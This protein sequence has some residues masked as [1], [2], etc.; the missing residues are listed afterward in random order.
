MGRI[1]RLTERDLTRLV[2]RVINESM[3]TTLMKP[4]K[5]SN[6]KTYQVQLIGDM[7]AFVEPNKA[8]DP[9]THRETVI[10]LNKI[11]GFTY[12]AIPGATGYVNVGYVKKNCYKYK[13]LCNKL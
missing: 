11:A 8:N 6:G 7:I 2:K 10:D 9:V 12:D 3:S 4:L 1:V 13:D 5:H